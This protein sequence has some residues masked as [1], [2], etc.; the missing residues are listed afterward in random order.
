MQQIA[1][2][3]VQ[4]SQIHCNECNGEVEKIDPKDR[5]IECNGKKVTRD[6]KILE[7]HI[8]KGTVY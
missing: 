1:P 7:V 8:D 6:R 3:F 2:G 5:C 4:Q